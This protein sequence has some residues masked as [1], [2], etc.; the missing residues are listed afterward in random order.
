MKQ[1]N[2]LYLNRSRFSSLNKPFDANRTFFFRHSAHL[3]NL[4]VFQTGLYRKILPVLGILQDCQ[5]LA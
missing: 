5:E 1:H 3:S 2:V 4:I